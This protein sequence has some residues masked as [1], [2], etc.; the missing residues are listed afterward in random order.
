MQH[1]MWCI[2]LCS[3]MPDSLSIYVAGDYGDAVKL[4]V[5]IIYFL[6][7]SIEIQ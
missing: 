4:R 6:F 1:V 2:V 3:Q 7:D 5:L